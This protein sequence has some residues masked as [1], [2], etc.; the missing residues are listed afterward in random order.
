LFAARPEYRQGHQQARRHHANHVI[1][2]KSNVADD[3][4]VEKQVALRYLRSMSPEQVE[5]LIA[6]LSLLLAGVSVYLAAK[7]ID[8]G[9]FGSA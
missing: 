7:R 1:V 4:T 3:K 8:W 6:V 5:L 9:V 2:T